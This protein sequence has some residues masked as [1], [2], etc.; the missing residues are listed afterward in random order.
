MGPL[1]MGWTGAM[2]KVAEFITPEVESRLR[3]S[4]PGD[5]PNTN[6]VFSR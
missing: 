3:T 5:D 6:Q 1:V 4:Q 2:Q